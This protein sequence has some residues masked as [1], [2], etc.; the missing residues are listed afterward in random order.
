M[1]QITINLPRLGSCSVIQ[2]TAEV[3]EFPANPP[4]PMTR[5]PFRIGTANASGGGRHVTECAPPPLGARRTGT[6]ELVRG[7]HCAIKAR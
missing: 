4:I 6:L 5:R 1:A 7:A 2:V 3:S